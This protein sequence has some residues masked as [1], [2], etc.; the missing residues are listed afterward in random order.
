MP[1]E[2]SKR[3]E[4]L[5]Q[6]CHQLSPQSKPSDLDVES[7]WEGV[8]SLADSGRLTRESKAPFHGYSEHGF[9]RDLTSLQKEALILLDKGGRIIVTSYGRQLA[10]MQ[11]F[12]EGWTLQA[13]ASC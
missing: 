12:P 13:I 2:T 11:C 1:V 3:T 8:V 7:L 6:I 5:L 4:I 9:A 10:S